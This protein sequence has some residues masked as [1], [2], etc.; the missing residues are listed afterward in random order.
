MSDYNVVMYMK[1]KDSAGRMQKILVSVDIGKT[2]SMLDLLSNSIKFA[3][4]SRFCNIKI[5]SVDGYPAIV[6]TSSNDTPNNFYEKKTYDYDV[7]VFAT[8]LNSESAEQVNS[9]KSLLKTNIK[10]FYQ[11]AGLEIVG[12]VFI[13]FFIFARFLI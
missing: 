7:T 13:L 12:D 5:S 4:V 6:F 2:Y 11:K 8:K 3:E 1:K 9:L 10:T